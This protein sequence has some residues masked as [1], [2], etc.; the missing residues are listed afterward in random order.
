MLERVA[1]N[2]NHAASARASST[3]ADLLGPDIWHWRAALAK[4]E[5]PPT[6]GVV[7]DVCLYL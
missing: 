4:G 2:R 5:A 6:A 1:G 7:R 3:D